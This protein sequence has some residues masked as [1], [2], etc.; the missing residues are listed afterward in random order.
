MISLGRDTT[1]EL[2]EVVERESDDGNRSL[3]GGDSNTSLDVTTNESMLEDE[4]ALA[5]REP[6][7]NA[8]AGLDPPEAVVTFL[9]Q[10]AR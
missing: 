6:H 10:A 7:G 5:L 2:V 9:L 4:L 1:D 8:F 3:N